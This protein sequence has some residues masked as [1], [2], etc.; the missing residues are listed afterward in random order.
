MTATCRRRCA[1]YDAFDAAPEKGVR[2]RRADAPAIEAKREPAQA[3]ARRFEEAGFGRVE[4]QTGEFRYRFACAEALFAHSFIR[5]AFV[6][7]W[8]EVLAGEV[9]PQPFFRE[10]AESLDAR[11]RGHEAVALTVPWMCLVATG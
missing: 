3:W 6:P 9:E 2:R 7:P 4:V 11:A 8:E 5:A 10:L 1:S